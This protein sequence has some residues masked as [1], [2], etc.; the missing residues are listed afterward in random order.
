[1]WC[2]IWIFHSDEDDDAVA[3]HFSREDGDSMFLRE[4]LEMCKELLARATSQF[5]FS[6]LSLSLSLSLLAT[7][8][9]SRQSV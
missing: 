9:R 6:F 7:R 5:I 1:M 2:E 8:L 4:T 3:S